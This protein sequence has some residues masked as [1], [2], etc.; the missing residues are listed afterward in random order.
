M[1]K[2]T[3]PAIALLM[4][5]SA[6]AKEKSYSLKSP[7]GQL[8]VVVSVD[9]MTSY[10]LFFQGKQLLNSSEISVTF[11]RNDSSKPDAWGK[12]AAPFSFF[13]HRLPVGN[14]SFPWRIV[15]PQ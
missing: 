6:A 14:K 9:E 5:F 2:Y 11:E 8:E 7:N 4:F 12:H 3:F 1:K 15:L 10:Q 13:N